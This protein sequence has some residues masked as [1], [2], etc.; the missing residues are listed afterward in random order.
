[1]VYGEGNMIGRMPI[2]G[3][4]NRVEYGLNLIDDRYDLVSLLNG[5]GTSG[6]E[7]VLYIHNQQRI[8]L[9]YH[10]VFSSI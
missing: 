1:M 6:A 4:D 3:G 2:T 7:I 9:F 8:F 5:E 10:C